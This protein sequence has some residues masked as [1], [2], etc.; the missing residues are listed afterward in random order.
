MRG[1]GGGGGSSVVGWV[2]GGE[3]ITKKKRSGQIQSIELSIWSSVRASGLAAAAQV[4]LL[5]AN[6]GGYR[7]ALYPE[8][9]AGDFNR[10]VAYRC[11][12]L[13]Q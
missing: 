1:G 12:A 8:S 3:T 10:F 5:H 7:G 4:G 11:S 13:S 2:V 6:M 9:I